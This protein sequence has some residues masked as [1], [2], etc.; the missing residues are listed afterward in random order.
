M[1]RSDR[2]IWSQKLLRFYRVCK[3]VDP[4][5]F[6][7][8]TK[9]KFLTHSFAK[10]S[11]FC[12]AHPLYL[13]YN[14]FTGSAVRVCN[15]SDQSDSQ[16]KSEE[17]VHMSGGTSPSSSSDEG[18]RSTPSNLPKAAT[19]ASRKRTSESEDEDYVAEEEATSKK[20]VLKKEYG[21]AVAIKPGMKIKRSV[22]R[23]PMPKARASTKIPEKPAPKE[24]VA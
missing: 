8:K 7:W 5:C 21:S 23:Q 1:T 11:V 13:I 19:R 14:L 4:K 16:N 9:I 3:S 18:S 6:L 12:D 17:Q 20:K 22:G 24:T 2:E 10:I 15:M